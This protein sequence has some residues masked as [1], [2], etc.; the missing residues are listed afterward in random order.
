MS[1]VTIEETT[2]SE[3][4]NF[5]FEPSRPFASFT[6][7]KEV[8]D[9]LEKWGLSP[10]SM[11]GQHYACDTVFRRGSANEFLLAL[12]NNDSFRANFQVTDGK[13]G[14][15]NWAPHARVTAVNFVPVKA[16]ATS[17][18]MFEKLE[19]ANIVRENGNIAR[20]MDI[21]LPGGVTVANLLRAVL[22][23]PEVE[24]PDDL[25]CMDDEH[26]FTTDE[27]SEFLYHVMRRV[28]SGGALCQW[29]DEMEPYREACRSLY[30][31]MVVVGKR[32]ADGDVEEPSAAAGAAGLEVQSVVYQITSATLADGSE[33]P[34][35]PRNDENA[36]FLYVSI[37]P[38]RRA[39]TVWYHGFWSP[40]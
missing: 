26:K 4:F 2:R 3:G 13:G 12:F 39:L 10:A 20:C 14:L 24:Q 32:I 30:K 25:Q 7:N 1:G 19:R 6:A 28:V 36:D 23:L 33:V 21:Y 17:L 40:F 27:R 16:T 37:H 11:L 31:D 34:L 35:F 8:L 38:H 18:D 15:R 22:M 5:E 29:D 9:S